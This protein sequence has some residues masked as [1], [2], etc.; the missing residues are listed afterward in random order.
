MVSD[1]QASASIVLPGLRFAW[2]TART[3]QFRKTFH[4]RWVEHVESATVPDYGPKEAW[5]RLLRIGGYRDGSV[6]LRRLRN[7]LSRTSLPID[8]CKLDFGLPGPVV[9]TIHASKGREANNV[10]MLIPREH[11][12]DHPALEAEETRI[13]FVG[14]TRAREELRVGKAAAYSGFSLEGGRAMRFGRE[15]KCVAMVEIGRPGDLAVSSI[16][17][18]RIMSEREYLETQHYLGQSA[19]VI[20][21]LKLE[22]D[23]GMNWRHRVY[24]VENYL[25]AGFMSNAFKNDLWEVARNIESRERRKLRPSRIIRHVR[26]YGARTLVVSEDDPELET[27]HPAALRTGF[28]LA[29]MIAAFTNVYFN[30]Y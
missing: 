17:G 22:T 2:G 4:S 3:L 23:P 18:R 5:E 13:L 15:G 12:F 21:K 14:A 29:P 7:R 9:G 28:L 26:A 30:P 20:T 11:A 27:L 1:S 8:L 10:T 6:S 25:C 24:V 19:C 16:A